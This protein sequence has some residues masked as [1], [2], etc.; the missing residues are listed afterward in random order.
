MS[1]FLVK[2]TYIDTSPYYAD[3]ILRI[4]GRLATENKT[5]LASGQTDAEIS[6]SF[7][8]DPRQLAQWF[9]ANWW[10][11]RWETEKDN[12][13]KKERHDWDMSHNLSAAGGGFTWP[14]INFVTDNDTMR[15]TI[16]PTSPEQS[17]IYF[18]QNESQILPVTEF[19]S[20]V[21]SFINQVT[22]K[23]SN[24][25]PVSQLWQSVQEEQNNPEAALW[26]KLEAKAGFDPDE[27]PEDL[28]NALIILGK[29]Y[30]E[31]SIAELADEKLLQPQ[32]TI[33][34]LI[35]ELKKS[36]FTI[37]PTKEKDITNL[38]IQGKTGLQPWK[39]AYKVAGKLRKVLGWQQ[40]PIN[41]KK[42]CD[43]LS[44]SKDIMTSSSV[45]HQLSS[46]L[47]YNDVTYLGLIGNN[48]TSKRFNLA[49]LLADNLYMQDQPQEKLLAA[50]NT[51]TSRQK[52]QRAF[53][54]ELL[55][56][57]DALFSWMDTTSPNDELSEKAA[58]HFMVSPML[59]KHA[60]ENHT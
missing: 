32:K 4:N 52:F 10:R 9:A 42:L 58:K 22:E 40:D 39:V 12:L 8:S 41:N 53:A 33:T 14:N 56:P 49:R 54:Q 48:L 5:V 37:Q 43:Y 11:L 30:G 6:S 50:T 25:D 47:K 44:V 20:G 34:N 19:E 55:C 17:L 59:V 1:N 2:A 51:R 36:K 57:A 21:A 3:L 45:A 15:C 27:G 60:V 26:R 7:I 16:K 23:L 28:V 13:S 24:D 29:Q 46:G 18:L 31:T 35:E 38:I